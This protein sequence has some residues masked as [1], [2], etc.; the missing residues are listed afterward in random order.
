MVA[1]HV[2]VVAKGNIIKEFQMPG[3]VNLSFD[4]SKAN[5]QAQLRRLLEFMANC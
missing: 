4:I 3:T 2:R 1:D 5:G